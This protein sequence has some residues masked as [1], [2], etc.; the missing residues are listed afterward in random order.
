MY[1]YSYT[2]EQHLYGNVM[3]VRMNDNNEHKLVKR[4]IIEQILKCNC[5]MNI[6]K[7]SHRYS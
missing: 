1:T 2:Q 7:P 5:K 4:T 3:R 6:R